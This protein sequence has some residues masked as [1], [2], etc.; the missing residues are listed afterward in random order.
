[1]TNRHWWKICKESLESK[2]E[3]GKFILRHYSGPVRIVVFLNV[4]RFV[5]VVN[6]L[7]SLNDG[8][9][10]NYPKTLHSPMRRDVEQF[11]K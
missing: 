7:T 9:K 2:K 11:V 10:E 8:L 6:T 1:M 3:K 4:F 5:I